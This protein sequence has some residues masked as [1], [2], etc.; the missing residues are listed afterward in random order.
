MPK[1]P[2]I[3]KRLD[4]LFK[5]VQPEDNKLPGKA[6]QPK[7]KEDATPSAVEQNATPTPPVADRK[8]VSSARPASTPVLSLIHI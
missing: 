7:A 8:P 5:D 4:A 2:K 3:N 6:E 1:K